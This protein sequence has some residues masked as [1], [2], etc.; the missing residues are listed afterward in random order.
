VQ[1]EGA[2]GHEGQHVDCHN[3]KAVVTEKKLGKEGCVTLKKKACKNVR[4]RGLCCEGGGG[5]GYS[6]APLKSETKANATWGTD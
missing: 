3:G 6:V 1:N 5:G 4:E 2:Y